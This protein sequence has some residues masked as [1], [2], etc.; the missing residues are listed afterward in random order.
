MEGNYLLLEHPPWGALRNLFD[1]T[2]YIDVDPDTR[3]DHSSPATF[4]TVDH[5]TRLAVRPDVG[6]SECRDRCRDSTTWLD[7]VIDPSCPMREIGNDRSG[8][9]WARRRRHP[10]PSTRGAHTV[11]HT[12]RR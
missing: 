7:A 9:P 4:V 12:W 10:I 11:V 3:V 8:S 2:G 6:R 1:L 5:S